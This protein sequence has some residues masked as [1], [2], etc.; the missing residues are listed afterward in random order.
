MC[1]VPFPLLHFFMVGFT[2]LT[3]RGSQQ[4]R[5]VTVPEFTQQMFEEHDDCFGSPTRTLPDGLSFVF[6]LILILTVRVVPGLRHSS[7]AEFQ[8]RKLRSKC[9]MFRTKT[10]PILSSGFPT[11]SCSMRHPSSRTEDGCYFLGQ[12][13]CH[14]GAV[15]VY[16]R[17]I[18]CHVQT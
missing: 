17:P 9:K 2:P 11:T 1:T 13:D 4:Y 18:H 15:Q 14:S 10:L 5:A 7:V 12:L 3:S 6:S 16:Q 8:R